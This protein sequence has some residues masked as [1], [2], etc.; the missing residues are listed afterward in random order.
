MLRHV[1]WL[2]GASCLLAVACGGST[3]TGTGSGAST[4]GGNGTPRTAMSYKSPCAP[5]SCP[6]EGA[7]D[8]KGV[9]TCSAGAS[10]QCGWAPGSPGSG[11]DGV[12]SFRQCKPSECPTKAPAVAC[13]AGYDRTEPTCGSENDG[14]CAWYS[15][16]TA[17]PTGEACAPGACGDAMPEIGVVCEA[18]AGTLVCGKDTA[19]KCSWQPKCP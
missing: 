18:G 14:P 19:G 6:S 1:S 5:E 9:A 15:T 3:S 13:A 7:S 12:V 11:G 10:G 4:G 2:L 8:A 16:C 17:R